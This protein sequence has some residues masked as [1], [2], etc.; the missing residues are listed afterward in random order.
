MNRE[1]LPVDDVLEDLVRRVRDRR[2]AVLCAPTGAGKTTRIPPALLDGAVR[3]SV[4]LV[5][6]RRVAARAAARRIAAERGVEPGGEIGYHVRFDRCA[7]DATRLLVVTE[8]VLLRRIQADPFLDGVGAVVFDEFHERN[9]DLDLG[10]AL[11]K[12]VRAEARPDLALVVMSATL[13]PAPVAGWLGN[14]PVLESG[15]RRHPVEIEY[16]RGGARELDE[17]I[18]RAVSDLLER[19]Q[20]DILVFLPGVGEIR[21]AG[22]A[23]APLLERRGVE[24][25]ELYGDLPPERQDAVFEPGDARRV[26]LATN[27]AETSVTVPRVTGVVDTGLQRTRRRDPSLG[28]DRLELVR[29]SRAAADQRAGRAGRG[30]AGVCVRLWTA[31]EHRELDERDEPEIRRVDLAGAVLQLASFGETDFASFDW[32]EPPVREA[33]DEAV[34]LLGRLGALGARDHLT[35][36]GHELARYPVHPRLAVLLVT[37]ARLGA[38]RRAALAAALL[39]ERNP[40]RVTGRHGEPLAHRSESD[41]LDRIEALEAFEA[42]GARARDATGFHRGAAR[43][44]LRV[45]D[46]LERLARPHVRRR[47]PTPV[48]AGPVDAD[49]AVLRA[50]LAAFPDRVARRRANDP[51]R[52]VLATGRGVRFD[53]RSAVI[54]PELVVC[55]DLDAGAGREARCRMAS[56][57]E[58][59]WLDE[60]RVHADVEVAFEPEVSRVVARRR[61]RYDELV[62]DESPAPLPDGDD[63]ARILARALADTEEPLAPFRDPELEAFVTRVRCLSA[64]MPELDLSP[65]D[66]DAIR[67]AL[68]DLCRGCRSF[69]DLARAPA[70]AILRGRFSYDRLHA[71]DR[72]APERI[73]VP[74]GSRIRIRY[75]IDRP[76]VLAVR[77]QEVFGLTETPRIAGGRVPLLLHLLGPNHR[78]QQVTDDL[79]SFWRRTYPEVR[80]ELRRRYPRHAW[81][82]DPLR[83]APERRPARRKR[84]P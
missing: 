67:E 77:I 44:V 64:W 57:V 31:A 62:L 84:R 16:H 29:V 23:L 15:G 66:D 41:L 63:V 3:G 51:A 33:I 49:E 47:D 52:G 68:P 34:A 72:E 2:A 11:A 9:L 59:A 10:L 37:G 19:T 38:P 35:P 71:V 26:I 25:L 1:P 8:G 56:R 27:V 13:D 7:T 65:L 17:A 6:P 69:D 5:E 54:E 18:A 55:V 24:R 73:E 80:K 48:D 21:R 50:V 79:A 32:F 81:P 74:S 36:L 22:E 30:A 78:P 42:G 58:R 46:R 76:P 4:I 60:A 43:S 53:A 12:R 61:T 75:E 14:A 40:F 20:G 28:I 83:A 82:E 70:L 39:S 45:R